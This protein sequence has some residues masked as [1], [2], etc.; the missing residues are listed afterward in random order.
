MCWIIWYGKFN[1]LFILNALAV[2]INLG[3]LYI[4]NESPSQ[5][6]R[7]IKSIRL[8]LSITLIISFKSKIY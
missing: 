5:F 3:I 7:I 1:S 8:N 2:F 6:V 4:R